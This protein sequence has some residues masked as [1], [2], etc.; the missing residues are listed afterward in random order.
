MCIFANNIK[1]LY[2]LYITKTIGY[3]KMVFNSNYDSLRRLSKSA[4]SL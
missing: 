4:K 1:L 3:E 2:K